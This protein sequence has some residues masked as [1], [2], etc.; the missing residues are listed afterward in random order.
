MA[1][2]G[3]VSLRAVFLKNGVAIYVDLGNFFGVWGVAWG[4]CHCKNLQGVSVQIRGYP[5]VNL[6][7][8]A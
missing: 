5:K 2:F 8:N 3:V 1:V 6:R 4:L 7:L